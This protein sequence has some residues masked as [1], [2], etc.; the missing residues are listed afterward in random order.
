MHPQPS[1]TPLSALHPLAFVKQ[2]LEAMSNPTLLQLQAMKRTELQAFCKVSR[3]PLLPRGSADPALSQENELKANGKT[4]VLIALLSAHFSAYVP[5]LLPSLTPA[6]PFLCDRP[7]EVAASPPA[8]AKKAPAGKAKK[9]SAKVNNKPSQVVD[10]LPAAAVAE[11]VEEEDEDEMRIGTPEAK[12]VGEKKTAG[13]VAKGK[14]VVQEQREKSVGPSS[15]ARG[16]WRRL[17]WV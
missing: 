10:K 13:K 14:E 4:D 16:A 12:K 5:L 8:P 15:E 1:R 2:Q 9:P 17:D 3:S 11:V 7:A 6:H